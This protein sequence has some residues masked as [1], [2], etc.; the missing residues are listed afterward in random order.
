MAL[1]KSDNVATNKYEVEVSVDAATFDTACNAAYRKNIK[2]INVPGFR[3][4]KAPR[5]IVEKMYGESIFFDD[6]I[7]AVYPKALSEAIEEAGLDVIAVESLEPI[8][9]SAEKGL[10]FKAT[11]ITKPV[12]EVKDYKGI[13]VTKSVKTVSD[14]DVAAELD[15][16]R[17]RNGRVI[18]VEDRPAQDGDMATFD[19]EGFLDGEAFEG[20]KAEKYTL[21]LGSGQ[22]IPGFEEQI[23]GKSIGEE[24]D[25]N[26]TF[27]EDYHAEEL[28]GQSCLF[29]CKLHELKATELPDADDEFAKDVSEFDTLDELKVDIKKHLEEQNAKAMEADVEEQIIGNVVENMTGEIPEVMYEKR[30]DELMRDFEYRLSSQ[31]MN[32]E[33]FMQYTGQDREAI[34]GQFLP[35]AEKQVK[36]RLAL[37]KVVEL[38]K[39]EVPEEELSAEYAKLAEQYKM[40]EDKVRGYIPEADLKLDLAVNK[41][42]A[43][44][45]DSADIT[46]VEEVK[47]DEAKDAE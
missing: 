20:G 47:E 45:K 22:F 17:E 16:M 6:A 23:V 5:K 32:L 36:V 28:K 24:F 11:C 39:V 21:K 8:E 27:P 9:A 15:K 19:F 31:G 3:R 44:L 42:I 4:G 12:V 1:M 10:S 38:E 7:D 26:V 25:V 35:Q 18:I 40:E 34:R 43:M 13:K 2:K 14:E 41:V 29:K 46:E 30:I 37:E 33:M